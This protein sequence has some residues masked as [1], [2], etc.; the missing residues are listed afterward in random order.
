VRALTNDA[1]PAEGSGAEDMRAFETHYAQTYF[2]LIARALKAQDPNHLYMGCRFVRMPPH[3]GIVAAAGR[4]ADAMSV[5]CYAITPD[6]DAFTWW[7][8][9]SG[10]PIVIGEHHLPLD[11]PRQL[12]PLYRNFTAEERRLYY[13]RFIQDW[14]KMPF[15][16]GAHWFQHADQPLTGRVSDG[17]NQ[18][19]G[20]VDITDEP[21]MDLVDAIREATAGMY[22][23]H[24]EG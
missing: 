23:W 3:A 14:A 17:E 11:S 5:N 12:P 10:K 13:V 2:R 9:T 18:L 19:I 6:R 1:V 21:H 4:Y 20:L 15:S 8:E 7:H 16:L 24:L 22:A